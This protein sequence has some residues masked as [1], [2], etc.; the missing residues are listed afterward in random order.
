MFTF[1]SPWWGFI[2]ISLAPMCNICTSPKNMTDTQGEM[3]PLSFE[4]TTQLS[5]MIAKSLANSAKYICNLF[6]RR[7]MYL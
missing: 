3:G 4:L 1:F 2:M 6:P 5:V 7:T